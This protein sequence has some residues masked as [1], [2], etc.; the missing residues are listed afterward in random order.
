MW[1]AFQSAAEITF[2]VVMQFLVLIHCRSI[3]FQ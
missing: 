3:I 2:C 1:E